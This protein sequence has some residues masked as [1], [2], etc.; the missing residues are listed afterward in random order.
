MSERFLI[1][2]VCTMIMAW[3]LAPALAQGAENPP[4]GARFFELRTYTAA[5]GKLDALLARF[6]DHTNA[7][8]EKHGMTII[9]FW[10]PTDEKRSKNTLIYILAYPSSQAREEAWR[11]FAA[12]PDWVAAKNASEKNGPLLVKNGV[13]SSYMTP[14]D[15]SPIK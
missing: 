11:A 8:F 6:R 12:D 2:L 13:E 7:L 14:T 9:G 10:V 3:A 5:P 1:A 4:A 15:F